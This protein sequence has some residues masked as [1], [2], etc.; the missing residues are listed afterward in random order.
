MAVMIAMQHGFGLLLLGSGTIQRKGEFVTATHGQDRVKQCSEWK[1]V[2][3]GDAKVRTKG[4]VDGPS[5]DL[6]MT[7]GVV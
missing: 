4:L 2:D 6:R 3:G 7:D 1:N 5:N